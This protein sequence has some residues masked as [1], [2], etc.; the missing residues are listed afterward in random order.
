M[1]K[2]ITMNFRYMILAVML[3]AL[4][5]C[6]DFLTR[7]PKDELSPDTYFRTETECQLYTNNFLNAYEFYFYDIMFLFG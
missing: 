1:K 3:F 7:S 2:N 6:E 4:T 5:A